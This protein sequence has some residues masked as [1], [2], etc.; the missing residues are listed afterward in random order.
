MTRARRL[1]IAGTAGIVLTAGGLAL[2]GAGREARRHDGS[3]ILARIARRLELTD[4]QRAQIRGI[5]AKHWSAGLGDAARRARVA[6]RDLQDA[7]TNPAADETAVRDAARKAAG[8][9]ED[10]AVK[11]HQAFAEAFAV[12]TPEQ[13]DKAKGLREQRRER[14]DRMFDGIDGA[15][16]G[17]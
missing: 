17:N 4:D 12:L 14:G 5:V 10:L 6:R 2:A 13:Q 7:I 9:A 3:G 8:A 11:R 15:L 1:L 16:R